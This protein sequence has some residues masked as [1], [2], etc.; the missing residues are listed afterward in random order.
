MLLKVPARIR[1]VSYEPA[2]G[3]IDLEAA[4]P[5]HCVPLE[6]DWLIAGSESAPRARV[7]PADGDW[8][9]SARDQCQRLGVYFFFKQWPERQPGKSLPML[10]GRQWN[11]MPRSLAGTRV[12]ALSGLKKSLLVG[13]VLRYATTP[14]ATQHP[15]APAAPA[16]PH[17]ARRGTQSRQ[18]RGDTEGP[19]V[20]RTVFPDPAFVTHIPGVYA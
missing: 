3:P 7:R 14:S 4:A 10:D 16:A 5:G 6:L 13:H 12:A 8:F 19:K 18:L 9:R 20:A 17:R 2:L 1:F 15:P 11:D